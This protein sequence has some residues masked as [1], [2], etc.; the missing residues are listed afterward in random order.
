MQLCSIALSNMSISAMLVLPITY[1][2]TQ[3]RVFSVGI[4][5]AYVR[6]LPFVSHHVSRR[7]GE[8]CTVWKWDPAQS[9]DVVSLHLVCKLGDLE[10]P[11]KPDHVPPTLTLFVD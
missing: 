2:Q 3:Y 11:V 6:N 7:W 10:L 4:Y 5:N 8:M 1:S 9:S